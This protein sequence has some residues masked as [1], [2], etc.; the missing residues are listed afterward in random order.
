MNG[1]TEKIEKYL[2]PLASKVSRQKYVKALQ[3]T[4]IGIIP[5]MTVGSFAL[6]ITEPPMDY[7]EM[8]PGA[9]RSIM[10]GWS[11]L[12][13]TTGPVL[14]YVYLVAMTLLALFASIGIGYYLSKHY[15]MDDTVLP[16][17]VTLGSFVISACLDGNGELSFAHFDGTGLFTSIFVSVLAFEFYR[18]LIKKKVGYINMES[19]GVPPVLSDSLGHLCP[20]AITL[21]GVSLG[22]FIVY[23]ITGAGVPNLITII[24]TPIVKGMDTPAG[25]II[26]GLVVMVFWFFGIHDTVITGTTDA[27]LTANLSVNAAAYA[28]GTAAT[29]LPFIVTYP[30]YWVF[31]VIGGSGA[32]FALAI[33]CCFSKSKQIKTIGKLGIIPSFFNI[34]E[35]IIFGL[36]LMYNPIMLF[37]FIFVMP[38]NGV[39]TYICMSTGL[40]AKTFASTGWNLFCPIAGFLTTMDIKALILVLVLIVI[41]GLI[42]FPFFKIFENQKLKEE[43]M[44]VEEG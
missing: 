4:F 14:N 5:F 34:N 36:P 7:T 19:M 3:N 32:T 20:A 15:E 16:I 22:S 43:S 37:P 28:A 6:I 1:L 38:M 9:G 39:I 26:L 42:Y 13:T 27:L 33:M 17:F 10:Q 18:F 11:W 2:L 31:M 12:A 24:M 40:V 21:V 41:D 23:A 35:P 25:I 29:A 8:A 44:Q 30:F